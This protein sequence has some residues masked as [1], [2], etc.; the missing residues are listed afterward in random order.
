M[1]SS[2]P[3]TPKTLAEAQRAGD[4]T[5]RL[6][7][8]S[9]SD[10]LFW[11]TR[12]QGRAFIDAQWV[13]F[14]SHTALFIPKA[15]VFCWEPGAGTIGFALELPS[16]AELPLP[17][18]GGIFR[19]ID[20]TAQAELT[21]LLDAMTTERAKAQ[22]RWVNAWTAQAE[23]VAVWINRQD[24]DLGSETA[25]RRLVRR[26]LDTASQPPNAADRLGIYAQMLN[27]SAAH[28]TTVCTHQ[29]GRS[30]TSILNALMAHHVAK[31]LIRKQ[32]TIREISEASGF[33]N[34]SYFGRFVK[35]HLGHPPRA[36]R[37]AAT[38]I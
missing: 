16:F 24:I 2:L 18:Q 6:P 29:T 33:S 7:H 38:R 9:A 10:R 30:A 19:R 14:G 37:N 31:E 28:R 27:V 22:P 15:D 1:T 12:G 5:L 35:K 17:E 21:R 36:F 26:F 34:V 8:R 11:I 23:L 20:S 13:G 25:S 4:W 32:K 3:T